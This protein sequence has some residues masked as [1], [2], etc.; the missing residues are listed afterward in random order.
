MEEVVAEIEF[1]EVQRDFEFREVRREFVGADKGDRESGSMA[2]VRGRELKV[3]G[4]DGQVYLLLAEFEDFERIRETRRHGDWWPV[5]PVGE[6]SEPR[7]LNMKGWKGPRGRVSGF[8][9][10]QS[11]N[12]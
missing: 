6:Y 11:V 12:G 2:R 8:R 4:R 10:V 1:G 7:I 5:G 3:L 9:A